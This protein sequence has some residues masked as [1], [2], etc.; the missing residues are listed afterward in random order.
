[1][2]ILS[3]WTKLIHT[4]NF[5]QCYPF[6]AQ[7]LV[8][9]F[10]LLFCGIPVQQ[11][12]PGTGSVAFVLSSGL[13]ELGDLQMSFSTPPCLMDVQLQTLKPGLD[14]LPFALP[15]FFC[16]S[17]NTSF[18][19]FTYL[20]RPI[21]PLSLPLSLTPLP[22]ISLLCSSLSPLAFSHCASGL[23]WAPACLSLPSVSSQLSACFPLS[24]FK[25]SKHF[26]LCYV[27]LRILSF[28]LSTL[29]TPSKKAWYV[30]LS[31]LCFLF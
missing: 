29:T 27:L 2:L 24:F 5:S 4:W 28:F 10:A 22:S 31:A 17:L 30:F 7:L 20:V 26:F 25:L 3:H 1:M 13:L 6:I 23:R 8:Q 21:P 18:Y 12:I 15:S 16:L 11:G 19:S 14:L 9:F